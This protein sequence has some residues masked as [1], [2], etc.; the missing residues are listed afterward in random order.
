MIWD[1]ANRYRRGFRLHVQPEDDT[2][3]QSDHCKILNIVNNWKV[4][5]QNELLN[6]SSDHQDE[7]MNMYTDHNN[8]A[9]RQYEP[10]N[11]AQ[12]IS[13][14]SSIGKPQWALITTIGFLSGM[15]SVVN[16]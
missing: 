4:F 9:S 7:Q 14:G 16:E 11:D 3:G 2:W 15:T 10:S 8:D 1:T 6:A 5:P 13:K 12:M